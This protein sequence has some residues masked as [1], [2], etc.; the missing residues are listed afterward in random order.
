L[1]AAKND[2]F[3]LAFKEHWQILQFWKVKIFAALHVD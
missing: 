3:A 2:A 1:R